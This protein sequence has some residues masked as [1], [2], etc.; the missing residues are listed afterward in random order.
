MKKHMGWLIAALVGL[1]AVL[2]FL[3]QTGA[4]LDMEL[5]VY[6]VVSR[7]ISPG[8]TAVLRNITRLGDPVTIVL[9]CLFLLLA[10]G[11]RKELGIPVTATVALAA[12]LN[13]LLKRIFQRERPKILW[14]IEE[15]GYSFP[16][17]HAMSN[18]A[19]YIML[20]L[21]LVRKIHNPRGRVLVT[22]LC[23]GLAVSIGVS[24]IYLGVHYVGD[25]A[26]GWTL[27]AAVALTVYMLWNHHSPSE[28]AGMTGS[29]G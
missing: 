8:L 12:G 24:R 1:F 22:L 18:S 19:L 25:V 11:L 13:Q 23:G 7:Y 3:I 21:M 6:H 14:L 16:S 2:A 15:H 10:P 5:A 28:T 20:A 29:G 9:L 26:A 27:G 17:G 4:L